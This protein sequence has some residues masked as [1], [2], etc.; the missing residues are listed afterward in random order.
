VPISASDM[1]DDKPGRKKVRAKKEQDKK[2]FDKKDDSVTVKSSPDKKTA[3]EQT[4]ST[5]T[6]PK[7][8]SKNEVL[9]SAKETR[10]KTELPD[11]TAEAK[12][13]TE[14]SSVRDPQKTA[15]TDKKPAEISKP[16]IDKAE[17]AEETVVL[18][19]SSHEPVKKQSAPKNIISTP[20][21]L[22]ENKEEPTVTTYTSVHLEDQ[23]NLTEKTKI[24]AVN[25]TEKENALETPMFSS[26]HLGEAEKKAKQFAAKQDSKAPATAEKTLPVT[27]KK[28]VK[29]AVRK[30]TAKKPVAKKTDSSKTSAKAKP[31]KAKVESPEKSVAKSKSA[32]I[33]VSAAKEDPVK[34]TTPNPSEQDK[35]S[36]S[37]SV[38]TT[39]PKPK[40]K[41]NIPQK[42]QNKPV[43][44]ATAPKAED[45]AA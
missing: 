45:S 4:K 12:K 43:K 32:Q 34:S 25:K 16:S 36:S 41:A 26:V 29:S 19:K 8:L 10:L 20:E 22:T 7:T 42:Q 28:S 17:K 6:P 2:E 5:E 9:K 15:E 21:K 39:K 3:D 11:T 27:E 35:N 18:F 13:G 24:V 44:P 1:R 23:H 38:K 31:K 37:K 14:E 30:S 40:P 33:K